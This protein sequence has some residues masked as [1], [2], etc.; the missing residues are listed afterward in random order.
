MPPR[1]AGNSRKLVQ[2]TLFGLPSPTKSGSSPTV[3][4]TSRLRRT[5]PTP[6]DSSAEPDSDEIDTH[7][8]RLKNSVSSAS[9]EDLPAASSPSNKLQKARRVD[10]DESSDA[11][12]VLM[13]FKS[14]KSKGKRKALD[15]VQSESDEDDKP[16]KRRRL[17]KGARPPSHESDPDNDNIASDEVEADSEHYT[18]T[19]DPTSLFSPLEIIEDRLRARGK[20]TVFQKNL[21]K[22]KRT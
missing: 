10:S 14:S 20:K 11:S 12:V 8:T 13:G 4:S 1:R 22:L 5:P 21:E 15:I 2:Q 17:V 9:E 3:K 7:R 16:L 19:T 6:S 18:L